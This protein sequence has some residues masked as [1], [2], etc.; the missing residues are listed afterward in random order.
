MNAKNWAEAKFGKPVPRADAQEEEVPTFG[1]LFDA[2][3]EPVPTEE[4]L[5]TS[6]EGNLLSQPVNF[7]QGM[8]CRVLKPSSRYYG[9]RRVWIQSSKDTTVVIG[10]PPKNA[11]Q[12]D[13]EEL[14][15]SEVVLEQ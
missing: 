4:S 14:N 13:W 5:S 8:P 12:L 6:T 7:Y 11:E 1:S 15:L 3:P 10:L 2:E 9:M